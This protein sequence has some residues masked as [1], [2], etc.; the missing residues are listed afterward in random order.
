MRQ[1][2]S[3]KFVSNNKSMEAALVVVGQS[4]NPNILATTTAQDVYV[5]Y[6]IKSYLHLFILFCRDLRRDLNIRAHI[7]GE[8]H[9]TKQSDSLLRER[10]SGSK[11]HP[12][13]KRSSIL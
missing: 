6:A 11:V 7:F 3:V 9:K 2:E 12:L 1:T 4:V 13:T 8:T 10:R 5:T